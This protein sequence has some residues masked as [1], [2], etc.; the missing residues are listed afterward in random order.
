M[1][2]LTVSQNHQ[3]TQCQ[4]ATGKAAEY[5]ALAG[6]S[7]I[8]P[9]PVF[10]RQQCQSHRAQLLTDLHRRQGADSVFRGKVP[11]HHGAQAGDGQ[12]GSQQPQG[13]D[14]VR[15]ADPMLRQLRGH[16]I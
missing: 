13:R 7:G 12:K 2:M 3:R 11:G 1:G 10:Q 9:C 8:V 5:D 15:A 6:P 4:A 16:K 14:S